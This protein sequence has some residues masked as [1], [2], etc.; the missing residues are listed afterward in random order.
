MSS[1]TTHTVAQAHAKPSASAAPARPRRPN[2]AAGGRCAPWCS[3][4]ASKVPPVHACAP[5]AGARAPDSISSAP[6]AM[7]AAPECVDRR[8]QPALRSASRFGFQRQ[9]H[10]GHRFWVETW[11][12]CANI[13]IIWNPPLSQNPISLVAGVLYLNPTAAQAPAG[14]RRE[15]DRCN[16]VCAP[17]HA[18]LPQGPATSAH[19]T[20]GRCSTRSPPRE[21]G[22]T[23]QRSEH[24]AA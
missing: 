13:I 21:T 12:R 5:P 19:R 3:T 4:S 1:E 8:R 11:N 7:P 10:C 6:G 24:R 20:A 22:H 9:A 15:V 14:T 18:S 16:L 2:R 17:P 23:P